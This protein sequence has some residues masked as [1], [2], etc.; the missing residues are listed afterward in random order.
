M[1]LLLLARDPLLAGPVGGPYSI[2]TTPPAPPAP[3]P[4]PPRCERRYRAMAP[5]PR[6]DKP[7]ATPRHTSTIVLS[8]QSSHGA[9]FTIRPASMP[10]EAILSVFP[11]LTQPPQAYVPPSFSD[12]LLISSVDTFT[13]ACNGTL[14]VVILYL[15]SQF[16][17][18]G[19]ESSFSS[20]SVL[21]A[22]G[23]QLRENRPGG[24]Q[25]T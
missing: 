25:F 12:K 20:Q 13:S 9:G 1:E 19:G 7:R 11:I 4:P 21:F 10:S 18:G 2:P 8:L 15:V 22:P 3:P 17:I 14:W 23:A 24:D 16:S 6:S 5:A